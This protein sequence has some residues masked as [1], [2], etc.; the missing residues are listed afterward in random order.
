MASEELG[1]TR[2]QTYLKFRNAVKSTEI[3]DEQ[4][5]ELLVVLSDRI[6]TT[7]GYKATISYE[8]Q[9]DG[10]DAEFSHSIPDQPIG[11]PQSTK[12]RKVSV[13]G[14][15]SEGRRNGNVVSTDNEKPHVQFMKTAKNIPKENPTKEKGPKAT[16]KHSTTPGITIQDPPRPFNDVT[17]FIKKLREEG[18][19]DVI[20]RIVP[21]RKQFTVYPKDAASHRTLT[22]FMTSHRMDFNILR[23]STEVPKRFVMTGLPATCDATALEEELQSMGFPNCQVMNLPV[24]RGGGRY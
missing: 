17:G 23:S 11:E 18:Q 3:S 22:D 20:A 12:R 13:V 21:R 1:S 10:M 6:A 4:V 14:G 5:Q 8:P 15:A 2:D 24:R 9:V 19:D 7:M 16:E